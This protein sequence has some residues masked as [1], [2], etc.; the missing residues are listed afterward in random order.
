M[1]VLSSGLALRPWRPG[2][3]GALVRHANNRA[4]WRNMTNR[5]PHPYTLR[6]AL[7]WIAVAN[8]NRD[9][10]RHYAIDHGGEAIG[11]VGFER[12][13]DLRTRTAEIGYW[14]GEPFWGRGIAPAALARATREAFG[15]YDF[16]RLQATVLDWNP[17]SARVLQKCGY[18]L[19]GIERRA[20]FKD[21][22][23]CDLHMYVQL[24]S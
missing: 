8:Q 22:Q 9:N 4:V 24:R 5:F 1:I 10:A 11:S 23:V 13:D 17:R 12:L 2:D 6:D 14:I 21:G 16:E 20:A 7:A 19:E 18:Q 15:A 3:E